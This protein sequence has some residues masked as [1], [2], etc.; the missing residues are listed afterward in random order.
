M[1][2][3]LSIPPAPVPSPQD[4]TERPKARAPLPTRPKTAADP[5]PPL[6]H[7]PP[8]PQTRTEM[9][10]P[11]THVDLSVPY[12]DKTGTRQPSPSGFTKRINKAC[13]PDPT[14]SEIAES[15]EVHI[16]H[17][18][19]KRHHHHHRQSKNEDS[20]EYTCT[21]TQSLGNNSTPAIL[22]RMP[23]RSTEKASSDSPVLKTLTVSAASPAGHSDGCIPTSLTELWTLLQPHKHA[24]EFLVLHH[25]F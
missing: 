15:S 19:I 2:A 12:A 10:R 7:P 13:A 11:T 25:Y 9:N 20:V 18:S 4:R 3:G 21:V 16:L 6:V 23:S 8:R 24:K 14:S 1:G 5:L 17:K 22:P